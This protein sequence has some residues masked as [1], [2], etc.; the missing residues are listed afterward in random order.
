MSFD[1]KRVQ[2]I[3]VTA[4]DLPAAHD[5]AAYLD[6]ACAGDAQLRC[7]VEALLQAHDNPDSW[8]PPPA[9][10]PA[11]T[12][13]SPPEAGSSGTRPPEAAG[14][15]QPGVVLAGRYKLVQ[16]IGEGGMG[17]VWLA[18][19]T[20]PVKRLVALKLIKP[21]MDSRQV[22]AR[23]EAER[24]ALALMDHPNIARV[25]DAGATPAGRPYFVMEL[26]K[27]VPIT[28][29]CDEHRL[30]PRERLELF[31][32]VCQAIQHAHQKGIIHR[33]IKPSNVLVASYDSRPVPKVIDFGVAKAAGQPLTERTLVTGLGAVVG[34]LEYMSPEQAQLNALDIDTRSDVY[35]LGVLLYELLTGTTPLE[36]RRLKEA[37]L[38]EVLRLIRE[39]EP[40][41]PSTRLSGT[42]ELPSVAANRGL[43]PRKL[44][45][46]VRGELDWIVMKALEKDRGRRYE[47]ANGFAQDVQRYLA[48]EPVLACPPSAAYRFRKFARRNRRALTI[49]GLILLFIATLGGGVSWV[50]RDRAAREQRLTAQVEL[51]LDEVERLERQQR[52]PEALA[53]AR[54]AEAALAGG[55]ADDALRQRVQDAHRDLAFVARLDRIR[56]EHL[57][58]LGRKPP[59]RRTARD[60][61]VAF[62]DY[63]VDVEALPAEEAVARLQTKPALAVVVA[64]AL[65]HWVETRRQLG[66]D[67]ASWKPLVAVARGLDPDPLRDRLRAVWGRPVTP[68]LQA[69]LLRLAES[70]DVRTQSPAT[71]AILAVTL[72]RAHLPEP[73]LRILR[74]GQYAHPADFW[75]T[76]A[77][78]M[79]RNDQKDYAGAERYFAA[80]VSLRPDSA[81]AENALGA[82]LAEHKK[83]DEAI[84]CFRRAIEI[85]PTLATAHS[86]LGSVLNDQGKLDEAASEN[87]KA[88]ELD[89]RD[90]LAHAGLAR[91]LWHQKK[92]DKAAAECRKAIQLDPNYAAAHHHLGLILHD[93]GKL[94]EAIAEWRRA[95]QLD[96][97]DAKTHCNLG[98]A[99]KAKGKLDQAVAEYRKAIDLDPNFAGPHVGLG[100][101]LC[102]EKHDYDGAIAE[103]RKAIALDPHDAITHYNLGNARKGKG[104]LEG[105][106]AAYREAIQLDQKFARAHDGLGVALKAQGKLDQAVAEYRKAIDLDPKYA[107]AHG[108]L[109]NALRAQ[110]KLDE[111]IACYRKAIALGLDDAKAHYNLGNALLDRGKLDEAVAAF[112]RA[113]ELD[114]KLAQ[115][116]SSRGG[117]YIGLRQWD[118]ALADLTRAIKVD[119]RRAMGWRNRAVAYLRLGRYDKALADSSQAIALDSKDAKAWDNRGEAYVGL[120]QYDKALANY[121]KA[122]ELDPKDLTHWHNRGTVYG[123]LGRYAKAIAD[124]SKAIDLDPNNAAPWHNRGAAYCSLG[125]SD[126]AIADFSKVIDLDPNKATNWYDRGIT[127]FHFGRYDKAVADFSRALERDPTLAD[128]WDYRGAAYG[129]HLGQPAKAVADFTKVLELRPDQARCWINR[130][131]AYRNLGRFDKAVADFSRAIELDPNDADTW[132]DR[133]AAYCDHLGQPAKAVA[134]FTKVIEL[135]PKGVHG[136]CNRGNA[137][138]RLDQHD[139]AVADYSTAIDLDGRFVA[140]W[141]GRSLAHGNLGR[142]AKAIADCSRAIELD[143]RHADAHN[144]LAWLLAT[145]PDAKLRDPDRAVA[146]AR[147]AV[148]LAPKDANNWGTLGTAHYRAGDW[149]AAVAALDRSLALKPG[150]DADAWLFLAMTHRKLG[151]DDEARRAYDRAIQWLEGHRELLAKDRAQA[152]ELRRFQAEAEEVLGLKKK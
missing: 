117:A 70:I 22:L 140:A 69:H 54:R 71:L 144:G 115:A 100:T 18:Q 2:A 26:V 87:R 110:K 11:G 96:P 27:G 48:D 77:A 112:S 85:D 97:N 81:G 32:P 137:F 98:V 113:I 138:R 53:A 86:N 145:C 28:R 46:L 146:L 152:E 16:E 91:W 135:R 84:T 15:E 4:A 37:A 55:E 90:A 76:T 25:L 60:Y 104:D 129:D 20:E 21:G 134:D 92:L 50:I 66:G 78:G 109:G 19:Q 83:L 36:R 34:T 73:A 106:V 142:Y 56:Q 79:A 63:G 74:D 24:Q 10:R 47:T 49:A 80:A 108:N 139:R 147:K 88:L 103:F 9:A 105:A 57:V 13:D 102:D 93:Q 125:Q 6:L 124:F 67:A 75:L 141:Y 51:I 128:A 119:P 123:K 14:T 126:G 8:L 114:P 107:P 116:W 82:A 118:K 133:G 101:F 89:P 127:Y 23:F 120:R 12:V 41:R 43:E 131:N 31:V 61:A 33:D 1:P 95:I 64:A 38:L 59:H 121:T 143:P 52:W 35:S 94:D 58:V 111:A 136:W 151:R 44:S 65:D 30:T 29:Y 68:G 99:L 3:F 17:A 150:W 39:E 45:G 130:G 148:Q 132:N 5:R 40:P 42:D 122:I 7:R 149:Q 72:A 62:R